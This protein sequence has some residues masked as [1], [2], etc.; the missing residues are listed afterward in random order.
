LS[1]RI[2]RGPAALASMAR[3]HSHACVEGVRRSYRT[4]RTKLG[5]PLPPHAVDAALAAYK[6]K[7]FALAVR[8]RRRTGGAGDPGRDVRSEAVAPQSD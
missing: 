4:A 7:G 5:V 2:S 6:K 3:H 8:P 1:V